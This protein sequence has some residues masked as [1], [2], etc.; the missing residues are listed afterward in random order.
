MA[1]PLADLL[2]AVLTDD[3]VR[4]AAGRSPS[5]LLRDHGWE[6]LDATD[7]REAMLVLADGAPTVEATIWVAGGDTIDPDATA[8]DALAAATAT[9]HSDLVADD[10]AALDDTATSTTSTTSTTSATPTT[11]DDTDTESDPH[12][13]PDTDDADP[14]DGASELGML[15]SIERATRSSFEIADPHTTRHSTTPPTPASSATAGTT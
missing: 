4:L 2:R 10:P 13:H 5:A 8:G 6:H 14:A 1:T 12:T 11:D 9:F 3:T 15:E 7:L